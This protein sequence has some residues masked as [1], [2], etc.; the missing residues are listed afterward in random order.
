MDNGSYCLC[1]Y[2]LDSDGSRVY[3]AYQLYMAD[4]TNGWTRV[5]QLLKFL[6]FYAQKHRCTRFN[7]ISSRLD[8]I[9]AYARGIGPDFKPKYLIFSQEI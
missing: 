7:L 6:K 3:T 4:S 1:R 5:R 8:N 9:Q 2:E